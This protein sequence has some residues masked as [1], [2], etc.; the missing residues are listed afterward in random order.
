MKSKLERCCLC[1][2][3]FAGDVFLSDDDLN[4]LPEADALN[5]IPLGCCPDAPGES[6]SEEP[7]K[8]R[9]QI[10]RDMAIDA[11]DLSLEGQWV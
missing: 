1:G 7:Q 10:T 6:D 2:R 4:L 3:F 9:H 11:G 8:Q 5:L